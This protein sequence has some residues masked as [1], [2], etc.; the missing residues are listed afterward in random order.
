[1]QL[2][3]TLCYNFLQQYCADYND[4]VAK[5]SNSDLEYVELDGKDVDVCTINEDTFYMLEQ[6]LH[7]QDDVIRRTSSHCS[8]LSDNSEVDS[9]SV[10]DHY[11]GSNN[12]SAGHCSS[13]NN[14][15]ID[16]GSAASSDDDSI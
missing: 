4:D 15:T 3:T 14:V 6:I 13:L 12:G 8:G 10:P 7:K 9:G 11:Y 5:D 16:Y 1:L 2:L